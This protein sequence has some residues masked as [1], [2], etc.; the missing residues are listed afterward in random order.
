M[1]LWKFLGIFHVNRF[2]NL[3][4]IKKM[5]RISIHNAFAYNLVHGL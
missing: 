5:R 4:F 1:V 2:K 3:P